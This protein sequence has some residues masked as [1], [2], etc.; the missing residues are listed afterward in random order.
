MYVRIHVEAKGP[1]CSLVAV[2]IVVH[3]AG[4]PIANA[5]V[6]E[7]RMEVLQTHNSC[8]LSPYAFPIIVRVARGWQVGGGVVL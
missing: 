8:C 1:K 2:Q 4:K 6:E 5:V 7:G 3:E